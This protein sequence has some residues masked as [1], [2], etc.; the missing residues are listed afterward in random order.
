M[1]GT[2]SA[3]LAVM[4]ISRCQTACHGRVHGPRLQRILS[5]SSVSRKTAVPRAVR[6]VLRDRFRECAHAGKLHEGENSVSP[7][8]DF[9][10]VYSTT[11]DNLLNIIIIKETNGKN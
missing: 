1:I 3:E 10:I 2:G 5:P 7:G 11:G 9:R 8:A 6:K 4:P